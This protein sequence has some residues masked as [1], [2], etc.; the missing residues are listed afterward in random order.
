M[1]DP[2]KRHRPLAYFVAVF[3]ACLLLCGMAS[4]APSITLSKKSGPPTSG[5][6]VSGRGFRPNVGVDIFF[7]TKDR[8]LIVTN[9]EGE[10]ENVRIHVPRAARPGKHWVTALERN[11]DKGAQQPFLVQTD[12]SQFHFDADGTRWNPYENVL[13]P[14]TVQS[15]RLK[16]RYSTTNNVWGSPAVADGVAYVATSPLFYALHANS[17]VLRWNISPPRYDLFSADPAV[18]NGIVYIGLSDTGVHAVDAR[19][20]TELW[21]YPATGRVFTSP[22]V[23]NGMVYFGTAESDQAFYALKANTGEL[24]WSYAVSTFSSSPVVAN[25]AVYFGA[26]DDNV[27]ALDASTG[28]K[29]WS[30][31]TGWVVRSSPAVANGVVYVGSYDKNV[32]ALNARTGALLWSYATGDSVLSSPAVANGVVY[33]GS[34][35]FKLYALNAYSGTKLWSFTTGDSVNSSPAVANN[36][37]YVGSLDGNVYALNAKGG[38]ELW[39]YPIGKFVW[40]SPTVVNGIVYVGSD[41]YNVYAFGLEHGAERMQTA[42]RRPDLVRLRPDFSLKVSKTAAGQGAL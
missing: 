11:N 29:L 17:G 16:W 14:Q 24:V 18:A 15:L 27:Y 25:G 7:D 22:A 28:A 8:A 10:F 6:A 35:D 9:G 4:A 5:I 38:T 42:S 1:S 20:G 13:N 30:Y 23:A 3:L 39:S 34:T 12:W 37:V 33:V 40:S 26:D 32:Y 21:N 19:N 41:D 31:T 2:Q 36:V